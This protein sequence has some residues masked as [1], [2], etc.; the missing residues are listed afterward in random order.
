ME[1]IVGKRTKKTADHFPQNVLKNHGDRVVKTMQSVTQN[2][3]RY[4]IGYC[5]KIVVEYDT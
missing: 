5:F 4:K 3:L 2:W 1:N